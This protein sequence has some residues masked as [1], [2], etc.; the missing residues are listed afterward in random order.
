L[1]RQNFRAPIIYPPV[2]L[3]STCSCCNFM[4]KKRKTNELQL[5]A[6]EIYRGKERKYLR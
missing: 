6:V 1:E 4:A 3:L 5:I 2:P